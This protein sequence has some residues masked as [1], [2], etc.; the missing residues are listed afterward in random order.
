MNKWKSQI[1][2]SLF[3][4]CFLPV[5]SGCQA[6]PSVNSETGNMK[7]CSNVKITFFTGGTQG[8]TF[9]GVV[10]NGARQAQADLGPTVSYIWSDWD[11]QKMIQQFAEAEA[12]KPDGI[13]LM[14]HPGDEAF[15]PLI[16]DALQ[17][18]IIITSQNAE[19]PKMEAGY[20]GRGFG[21]VGAENYG[22]GY[23]L[24]AQAVRTFHILKG[25]RVMVWG[26]LSQPSRGLRSKGIIDSLTEAGAKVD[27]LE[28]DE[29][30]NK[31]PAAGAPT[32]SGY[33]SSHADVKLVV[34]DHGG[35]TATA[36]TYMKA[37]G[38]K[39]GDIAIAGF[40]LSPATAASIKS[41]YVGLVIDQQPWLQGY[42]PILNI[43]LT[44]VYGFS[45][46]H[47]NTG[48]GFV[49]I[50]NIDFIEPLAERGIR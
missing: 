37:A 14:G 24:G 28:I 50:N 26:L 3:V 20:A 30:T 6:N 22:A 1:S 46:L 2:L 40:D 9:E 12:M 39:P 43:C 32:F 13:A 44:K 16:S 48:A 23:S 45:G 18:G 36:E 17:K 21:Y 7:W 38:K 19:L 49:D 11:P 8:G 15:D 34:I 35:M 41:G 29:A 33:V 47:I 25:D 10:Y 31:D 4:I 5:L 27:V 42:L